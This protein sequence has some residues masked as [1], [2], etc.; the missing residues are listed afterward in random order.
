MRSKLKIGKIDPDVLKELI[1]DYTHTG[2]RVLIGAGI[3]EDA[4]IIDMG[5][6]YLVAKTDPITHVTNEIGHYTVNINANDIAAMGGKPL[7]FLATILMPASATAEEVKR[8]F[9][10]LSDSCKTLGII[11]CGGH[12]EVTH[13]VNNPIVIGQMLGEVQKA[14]LKPTSAACEGDE[15]IMTKTSAIEATAIIALEKEREL[16]GHLKEELIKKA[17]KYLYIPGISVVREADVIA[18]ME[19]VH[20]LHDPTEG[21]IATGIFEMATAS[22]LGVEVYYDNI[23]ISEETQVMCDL[24]DVDPL[25]TFAS[26]SLLIAASPSSS[27]DVIGRLLAA[28]IHATRIGV[29]TRR[30]RGMRLIKQNKSLPLPIYYQDE[31]SK[32]FG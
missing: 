31:L 19:A 14:N 12:T 4:A 30:E 13:S 23:P 26:G 5:S 1:A 7:W 29:M 10:Q 6:S 18:S 3:G 9:S 15:L 21:G 8:L 20:A 24:Y 28:G 32:I 27:E 2:N 25:G 17:K 22:N 16:K 11:Y